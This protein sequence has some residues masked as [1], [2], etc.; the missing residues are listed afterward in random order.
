VCKMWPAPVYETSKKPLLY[1]VS[2]H[3]ALSGSKRMK[4]GVGSVFRHVKMRNNGLLSQAR[5]SLT[6][7]RDGNFKFDILRLEREC[8]FFK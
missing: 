4:E 1:S 5:K 6:T 2:E 3:V 7:S 8:K